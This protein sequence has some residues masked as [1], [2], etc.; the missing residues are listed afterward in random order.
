MFF[1]HVRAGVALAWLVAWSVAPAAA[2]ERSRPVQGE[3]TAGSELESYLRTLQV[4]G[5][6]PYHPWA[7]RGFAPRELDRLADVDSVHPWGDRYELS[8]PRSGLH[9]V[10]PRGDL[11][12]NSTFPYGIN[13]GPRWAG[14]GVTA[15]ARF[16]VAGRWGPLSF[17]VIPEAFV[18]Q[19]AAFALADNGFS[20]DS[21]YASAIAP[22][23]IDLPQR[24]GDGAYGRVDPGESGV[25]IDLPVV[26]FG[27]GTGAQ[28]WGPAQVH[29]VILGTNAGGFSHLFLG[30]SEPVNVGLG[31]V[32]G[33]LV[34]GRLHHSEFALMRPDTD[35]RRM[36]SG[37]VGVFTPRWVPGLEIGASR[38]F[39]SPWPEDGFSLDTFL[40]PLEGLLKQSLDTGLADNNDPDNQIASVFARWS[41]PAAG[42]EAYA[43]FG[44]EDHSWNR[45]DLLLEPDHISAYMLGFRRVWQRAGGAELLAL[46]GEVVNGYRSHL[47]RTRHQ[48]LFYVH[49]AMR[50]GHTHRG[51]ILGSPAVFGGSG[52]MLALDRYHSAGRWSA[53][54]TRLVAGELPG[55]AAPRLVEPRAIDVMHGVELDGVFFL[56]G[57]DL[58]ARLSAIQNLNRNF[59][60]D[61][62]NLG[63]AVGAQWRP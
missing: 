11:V 16:G 40:K 18:A 62:F 24:F 9:W 36:M 10:A 60:D 61:R 29:P 54:L 56:R 58:H 31:R 6:A 26:A 53:Q 17:S 43:E 7:I 52:G 35:P 23:A 27:A 28:A 15:A 47:E 45:R 3:I 21:A 59:Q 38:F 19:N 48:S 63:V 25:R 22:N 42:F 4:G 57:L 1:S 12:F 49:S 55:H 5:L 44:R 13:N 20:G 32:H 34:W 41:F 2:Q 39:H 51:Q 33:R 14:R 37:L 30:T 46:R 50:Q 8:A